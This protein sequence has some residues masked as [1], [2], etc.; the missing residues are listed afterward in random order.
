[1]AVSLLGSAAHQCARYSKG[2]NPWLTLSEAS[3]DKEAPISI[4][5]FRVLA[6]TAANEKARELGWIV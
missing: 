6:W 2:D 1:M 3:D 5:E 4:T